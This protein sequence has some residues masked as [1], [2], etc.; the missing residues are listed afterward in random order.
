MSDLD[1]MVKELKKDSTYV[2]YKRTL[3][4]KSETNI[5]G[6][7]KIVAQNIESY[8]EAVQFCKTMKLETRQRLDDDGKNQIIYYDILPE[9]IRL[10]DVYYNDPKITTK[11]NDRKKV[12]IEYMGLGD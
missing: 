4:P 12:A 3:P 2:I 9:G 10:K 5:L 7:N 6:I 1:D 8:A 11:G